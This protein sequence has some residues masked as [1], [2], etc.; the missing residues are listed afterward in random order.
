MSEA[1]LVYLGTMHADDVEE[2]LPVDVEAGARASAL[3][4]APVSVLSL[5][6]KRRSG[7][8]GRRLLGEHGGLQVRLAAHDGSQ[9]CGEISARVAVIGQAHRHEQ[10]AEVG[11]TEAQRPVVV[12]IAHDRFGRVAGVVHQDVHGGDQDVDGMAVG[13]HVKGSRRGDELEQVETGQVARRVIQEHVL[14]AW[15]RGIDAAR[16]L[17]GMPLVDGGVVLHAGVAALPGSF[18]DLAHEVAS[19]EDFGWFSTLDLAGGEILIPLDGAHEF[20]VHA[21]GVVGVL[22]K[23]GAVRF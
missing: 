10:G 21:H 5:L 23:D 15:V 2:R 11:V 16:V 18:G 1:D 7:Y 13:V 19:F 17:G 3:R 14:R 9:G 6:A 8:Q 12:G 4:Q 20:V 22:E